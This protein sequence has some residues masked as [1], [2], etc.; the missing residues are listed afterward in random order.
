[1]FNKSFPMFFYADLHLHSKYSRA[2][3]RDLDLEHLSLWAQ[4]KGILLVGTGDCLHPLWLKELEEKLIPAEEGLFQLKVPLCAQIQKELPELCRSEVRFMLTVEVSNIY[5]KGNKVRKIHNVIFLPSFEAAKKLQKNLSRSCNLN[6]DGRPIMGLSAKD[7]LREVLE[8][9]PFSFLVPAHI[10]TPWFSVLGSKS[11]FDSIEEC[12]ED[13]TGEIFALETGLSSDPSMNWR[14]G[15]LDSFVLISN[16]DA[17]SPRNLGREATIFDTELNYKSI[18]Y[19]LK[20]NKKNQGLKG[21]IE[22]FPDEGKY[23]YDGN[24][25]YELRLHP[26]ETC[27]FLQKK[28]AARPITIGVLNRVEQLAD[29]PEGRCAPRSRPFYRLVP[30]TEIIGHIES[31][32]SQ[33]KKVIRIYE[34]LLSMLGPELTILRE[35][36]MEEIRAVAGDSLAEAITRMREGKL[37]ILPGYD[38]VFGQI[39]IFSQKE[40]ESCIGIKT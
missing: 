13:L 12:F 15:A 33:S 18:Y 9:D 22:F 39:N 24:R 27:D 2:T 16:S 4:K 5:K 31:V 25:Q 29:Q 23:F 35:R 7:L 14:V 30:L 10:W 19:A 36:S 6:A 32:G 26:K 20:D 8:T 28:V 34:W 38:G 1:M 17:H 40:L 37:I 21:T 3:S 11:G